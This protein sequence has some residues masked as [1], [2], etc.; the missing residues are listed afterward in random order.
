MQ[1]THQR[2]GIQTVAGRNGRRMRNLFSARP[3]YFRTSCMKH[4]IWMMLKR[5]FQPQLDDFHRRSWIVSRPQHKIIGHKGLARHFGSDHA[6]YQ[7]VRGH[8][9]YWSKMVKNLPMG[10]WKDME[11]PDSVKC[12][13][14]C[15][16][17]HGANCMHFHAK[18][19]PQTIQENC[20]ILPEL[21]LE[22][23]QSWTRSEL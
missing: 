22:S 11:V 14:W 2:S 4:S 1:A 16:I 7:D 6:W 19:K 3:F 12:R 23:S 20:S 8:L 17:S 21:T 10:F 5:M 15:S 18:I 9:Q 13:C